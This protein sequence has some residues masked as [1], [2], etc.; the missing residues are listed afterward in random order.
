MRGF[1]KNVILGKKNRFFVPVYDKAGRG[2]LK[3]SIHFLT[4]NVFPLINISRAMY[5]HPSDG[6]K[7]YDVSTYVQNLVQGR[8]LRIAKD[9]LNLEHAFGDPC[10]GVRK[11]LYLEYLTRGFTGCVRVR[12]NNDCL[13]ATVELGFEDLAYAEDADDFKRK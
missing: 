4:N 12:E 11:R 6:T 13:V 8:Y 5:G 1:Q 9:Y 7:T 3:E 10:P 2:C